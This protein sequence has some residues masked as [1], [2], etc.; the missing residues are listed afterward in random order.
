MFF[1]S[2][3]EISRMFSEFGKWLD[4][5]VYFNSGCGHNSQ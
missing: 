5:L 4:I 2:V 3:Y 1:D